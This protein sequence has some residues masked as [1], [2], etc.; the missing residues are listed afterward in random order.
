MALTVAHATTVAVPDDGTSP[1]GSDEWNAAHTV[2]GTV[3]LSSQF[4]TGAV[5]TILASNGS[6]AAF[7]PAFAPPA[8]TATVAPIDLAPGTNLTTA[9]GG[10]IEYDGTCLYGTPAAL[11]RGVLPTRHFLSLIADQT[12]TN[13]ATAQPWFPGGGATGI[14]LPALTSY[15]FEGHLSFSRSAGT[16]SHTIAL[17]FGG[18]A[19]ITSINYMA[20]ITDQAAT[21]SALSTPQVIEGTVA[22]AL[23]VTA[24]S[25][26]ASQFNSI[27]VKGIVRINGA[28]TFIPQFQYSAAPG[29]APSLKAN[30]FFGLYPTGSNTVLSVGNW[31]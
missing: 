6:V 10:A 20:L 21:A 28:G 15:F 5:G 31:S 14:T 24:A 7:S 12:G 17:L 27:F 2:T 18:V 30:S 26:N 16:T 13:V 8:G 25:A 3:D 11:N 1:V 29:G 23:V 19:T 9:A 4:P 22:T